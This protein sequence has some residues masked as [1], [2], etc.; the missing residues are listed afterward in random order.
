MSLIVKVV[1]TIC[2][3][4][5][6]TG[7]AKCQDRTV[8]EVLSKACE[9][10]LAL[11][12]APKHLRANASVYHLQSDGYKLIRKGTNPFTC[13]VNRD[14][15][16]VLKP[17]CFD[18]EGTRTIIPKI[19]FV[20]KRLLKGVTVEEIRKEINAKFESQEFISPRRPGVAYMLSRYNRPYNRKTG[21]L[22]W[23]PP[24]VM[25]YAPNLTNE[26]IGFD[27]Q[28]FD[29]K[30]PTPGIGYQG[31]HGFM[32]QISDDGTKRSKSDLPNCPSWI[33]ADAGNTEMNR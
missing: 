11:S 16:N 32:I 28:H 15:P 14:D 9:T 27:P 20:G 30:Q 7:V 18:V 17:T 31:P 33:F 10:E 12:A 21:V 4:S 29:P 1:S 22:G 24:H 5:T 8:P 19:K 25:Y 6:L 3:T 2:L 26:D 13:I 23:F